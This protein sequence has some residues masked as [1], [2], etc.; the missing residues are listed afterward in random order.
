MYLDDLGSQ[1]VALR[2]VSSAS[3]SFEC[4]RTIVVA[5]FGLD[6]GWLRVRYPEI[7]LLGQAQS[8]RAHLRDHV[9]YEQNSC[10][11]FEVQLL[12]ACSIH[13]GPFLPFFK[14]ACG[15][16][17]Y[18]CWYVLVELCPL[19]STLYQCLIGVEIKSSLPCLGLGRAARK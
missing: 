2:V 13:H 4:H 15:D 9:W 19:K 12:V 10:G 1:H 18:L 3:R 11:L 5:V 14:K 7:A 8:L 17:A 16:I 6:E